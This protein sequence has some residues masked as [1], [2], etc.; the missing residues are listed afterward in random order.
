MLREADR[1]LSL[2]GYFLP[3][4]GWA[5][6]LGKVAL[7]LMGI[8]LLVSMFA[9][10]D[11]ESL[12]KIHK[13]LGLFMILGGF[14]AYLTRSNLYNLPLLR[15]Y[16][17]ILL[18]ASTALYLNTS[19]MGNVLAKKFKYEV[20]K[21]N[22]LSDTITQIIMEP[23]EEPMEFEPGQFVFTRF[24][25]DNFDEVHPFSIVSSPDEKDLSICVKSLGDYTSRMRD[26]E[27]GT[28]AIVEGAYGGF[29]VKRRT[30]EQIWIA[31]GIG[32]T[33]FLSMLSEVKR[34]KFRVHLYYSYSASGDESLIGLIRDRADDDS[35]KLTVLNTREIGRITVD[36]IMR[37][38]PDFKEKSYCICGPSA[39]N[40]EF[41]IK[42]RRAGVPI[43]NIDLEYFQLL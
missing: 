31:G 26:L 16:T 4:S 15:Y 29:L 40:E 36:R 32:I 7:T 6:D 14:H 38:Y 9:D 2:F 11:Y 3:G 18:T 17:M 22:R 34:W 39:M 42:L 20:K 37:D 25:Q 43:E 13:F 28:L 12:K 41:K 33:P 5:I 27:E 10:I 21:V 23:V 30:P 8:S 24:R 35:I 1:V 19:L